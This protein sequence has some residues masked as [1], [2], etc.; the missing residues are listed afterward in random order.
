MKKKQKYLYV[1]LFLQN[2]ALGYG[3]AHD[4]SES[5]DDEKGQK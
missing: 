3:N 1:F 2:V 4:K 5:K